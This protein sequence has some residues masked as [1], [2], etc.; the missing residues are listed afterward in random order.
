MASV[1]LRPLQRSDADAI[2]D[3]VRRSDRIDRIPRMV[4][5]ADVAGWFADVDPKSDTRGAF[6]RRRLTSRL[7]GYARTRHMP[8]E[9]GQERCLIVGVVAP[10]FRGRGIG[11]RLLRW[12]V[13]RAAEQL[14]SSGRSLPRYIRV[15]TLETIESARRLYTANG[16]EAV[17]WSDDMI[18][19][20]GGVAEPAP[21]DGIDLVPWPDDRNE[22]IR[23]VKNAAFADHWGSTPSSPQLWALVSAGHG[24]RRDCS[25]VALA[26]DRIVALCLCARYPEAD[27]VTGRRDGWINLVGTLRPY[28]G[29]GIATALV[30]RSLGAFDREGLTHA[31]L[32]VDA[33]SP[34]GAGRLYREMGFEPINRWVTYQ[35][36]V[37]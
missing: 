4:Q 9:T 20:L 17:R 1:V 18:R 14:R 10:E 13:D 22:E 35:L 2:L 11:G 12:G 28:R 6:I 7:V 8:A 27:Q 26:G 16:L 15:R 5:P 31:A 21:L 30:L 34:T 23:R 24:V 32:N 36:E 25:S 29:R 19:P 3:V 33:D 37:P